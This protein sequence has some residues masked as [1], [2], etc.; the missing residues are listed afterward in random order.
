MLQG[1]RKLFWSGGAEARKFAIILSAFSRVARRK[2]ENCAYLVV[3][4]C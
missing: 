2:N 3:F 4:L 1:R